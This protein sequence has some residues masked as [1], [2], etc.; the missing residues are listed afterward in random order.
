[1]IALPVRHLA[2]DEVESI[3]TPT[4]FA[5]VSH[6]Y[7]LHEHGEL[8]LGCSVQ[9]IAGQPAAASRELYRRLF[10]VTAGRPLFRIWNYVPAINV[11]V[12]G[13]ENY[14]AFCTGRAEAFAT[15]LG[16]GFMPKLP[17]ASAVGCYGDHLALLFV[18]GRATPRH[19]ENPQQVAAY[20]Y[21]R[22]HGPHSPSFSRATAATNGRSELA[23]I[24]GTAA[25]KGHA[26]IAPGDVAGQLACTC[27]NL[28]L[29]GQTCGVG[30]DLGATGAWQRHFKIYLRHASDLDFVSAEF[31]RTFL[32][33]GDR[34]T[35]LEADICRA[36]LR[37]EI[38]ATLVGL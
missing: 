24:S 22:E 37:V 10:A 12:A 15:A 7:T 34:V 38:E 4:R 31:S 16:A 25:I 6:G 28:R 9:P 18:A 2:G 33:V 19:F 5:G 14:R 21:P 36:A 29:I 23:F 1:M 35:Y 11:E 30:P 17:A 32:R 27:D 20:R 8:L 26:T 13:L 3:F